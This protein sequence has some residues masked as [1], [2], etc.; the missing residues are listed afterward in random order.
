M[1][2]GQSVVPQNPILAP[3]SEPDYGVEFKKKGS[4]DAVHKFAQDKK[5]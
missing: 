5:A 2:S 3:L 1:A 4:H